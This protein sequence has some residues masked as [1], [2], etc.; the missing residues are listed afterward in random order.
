MGRAK[1]AAHARPLRE[2]GT[3]EA[4]GGTH[5]E[6]VRGDVGGVAGAGPQGLVAMG[7]SPPSRRPGGQEGG[8]CSDS[9]LGAVV[10]AGVPLCCR[11][12]QRDV[13]TA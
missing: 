6:V 5:S 4:V 9:G 2:E 11:S 13:A 3:W 7:W 8:R 10:V 1:G 12:S